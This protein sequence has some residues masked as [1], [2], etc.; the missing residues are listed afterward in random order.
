MKNLGGEVTH[1]KKKL[2][3]VGSNL[4]I[5]GVQKSL[6]NLL[7]EIKDL[8]DVTLFIFDNSGEYK[9]LI[10]SQVKVIEAQS[11]LRLLG[12][13]QEQ[14]KSMGYKFYYIRAALVIY[15]KIFGNHFPIRLLISTQERLSGFDV[16]VSYWHND[17]ESQLFGGCNEFVLKRVSAKHKTTFLHCDFLNYG[18]NT[19][20]N[21]K[22]YKYFDKIAAVSEGCRRSFI[23]AVPSL[24]K[25]TFCVYNCHNYPEFIFMSNDNPVKYS[26]QSLN[27]ITVARLSAEKGILRTID[28][29]NRLVKEGHKICWHIIG[30]GPKRKEIEEKVS[31]S[32]ATEYIFL[33]GNQENPYRYM[34]NADLLLLPSFHEAAPM[35]YDEAK[36]LGLAIIT[37]NTTSA[38]EMVI[39][40]KEGF[41]CENNEKGIYES[42]KRVLE[43][44]TMLYKYREYLVK[45]KRSNK[46]A[47][48]QF[49][50]L[51]NK[52]NYEMGVNGGGTNSCFNI[53][54]D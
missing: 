47:L 26:Q 10:P 51:M 52:R 43:N 20:R 18:G 1:D 46:K 29:I 33:Y 19:L 42:L 31:H 23:N 13:S 25:K 5:G 21:R 16:A 36:C 44:P 12:I 35:V 28:I 2:L 4:A 14:S 48:M 9:S 6:I 54:I 8:Y 39:D 17:I 34:K 45:Q 38:K 3:L 37:T 41:V 50:N 30:D 53:Y 49:N 7:H 40:G 11:Y 22:V 27:I 32:F 15:S 24:A